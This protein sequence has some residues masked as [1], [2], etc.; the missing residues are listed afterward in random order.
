MARLCGNLSL[1]T[2]EHQG[3]SLSV[4]TIETIA[5]KGSLCLVGGLCVEK[6]INNEAFKRTMASIW[7]LTDSM[8]FHEVGDQLFVIEFTKK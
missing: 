2:E 1:T 4:K 7:G 6:L 3:V 8:S 5:K